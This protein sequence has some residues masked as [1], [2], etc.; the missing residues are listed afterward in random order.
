[1]HGFVDEARVLEEAGAY[2]D[3]DFYICGPGPF[4]DVVEAALGSLGIA[5]EQI[6]IERF[7]SPSDPGESPEGFAPPVVAGEG[8]AVTV[9]LDGKET[10]LNV[11]EG[12]TVLA[13]A[14]RIGLEPPFACEEAYCGCCMAKVTAGDIEMLMNDG[15]ID[16]RQIDDGW[17]L[18]CQAIPKSPATVEYP[19]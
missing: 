11:G 12:E 16:Q 1:V 18:T 15:G 13:A 5:S 19:D 2:K 7:A 10:T 3:A 9:K 8:V 6:F 4:M 14:R 17:V